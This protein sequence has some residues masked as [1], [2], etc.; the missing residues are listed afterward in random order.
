MA[1]EIMNAR[2]AHM[3][4]VEANWN[5]TNGFIPKAGEVIAYDPD[6][7]YSY[8]RFKLGDGRTDVKVL[9]F[10][11]E[12]AL[13]TLLSYKDNIDCYIID[14]GRISSYPMKSST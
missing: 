9:P 14:A 13:K 11:T 2:V 5:K 1:N 3:H 10:T 8:S 7:N 12:A 4:D 6:A